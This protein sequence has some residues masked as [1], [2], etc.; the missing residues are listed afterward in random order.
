MPIVE[1]YRSIARRLREI[2]ITEGRVKCPT[3][4]SRGWHEYCDE[5]GG[6]YFTECSTCCNPLKLPL[7]HDNP[8]H[9]G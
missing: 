1:E 4:E 6:V 3:C 7:K 2:T 5:E 9:F 8:I